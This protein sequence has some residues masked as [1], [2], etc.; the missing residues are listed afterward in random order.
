MRT[1]TIKPKSVPWRTIVIKPKP[2]NTN[3]V[4]PR[5]DYLVKWPKKSKSK[6]YA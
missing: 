6:K 3:P 5:K 4:N 1:I 2:L